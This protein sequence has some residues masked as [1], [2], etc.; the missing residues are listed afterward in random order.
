MS[1]CM[2]STDQGTV[3]GRF[4]DDPLKTELEKM[5]FNFGV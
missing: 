1:G 4:I 5:L 3:K 2:D